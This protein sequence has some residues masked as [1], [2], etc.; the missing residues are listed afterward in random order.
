MPTPPPP[1]TSWF[2]GHSC[3]VPQCMISDVQSLVKSSFQDKT[4]SPNELFLILIPLTPHLRTW[5]PLFGGGG[6]GGGAEFGWPVAVTVRQFG[7]IPRFSCI[8]TPMIGSQMLPPIF[9]NWP[10][11]G[12]PLVTIGPVLGW[13]GLASSSRFL[14]DLRQPPAT[15]GLLLGDDLA[16]M[17]SYGSSFLL[18]PL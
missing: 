12:A 5:E 17:G 4:L 7:P 8:L 16:T 3:R 11:N 2:G 18:S 10:L 6:G 9:E 14:G 15:F 1:P 13:H